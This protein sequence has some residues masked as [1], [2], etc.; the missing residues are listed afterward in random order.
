VIPAR[1]VW[2]EEFA[3]RYRRAGYWRGETLGA[4]LC[5]RAQRHQ[6]RVAVI[7]GEARWTYSELY[8]RARYVAEAAHGIGLR[9]GDRAIVQ[10]PNIPEFFSVTFGLFLAGVVPVFAL[11]A[12]RVAEIAHFAGNAEAEAYFI[13]STHDGFDYRDLAAQVRERV[14]GVKHVIVAA[15][16]AGPFLHL[17]EW[18]RTDP[19]VELPEIAAASVALMQLSGGSTGISKL[20]PR[21]HDDYLY[22]IRASVEICGLDEHSV[23]MAT[24]PVAHNFPM[25]SPGTFGAF[26]AGAH[27]VLTP[28]LRPDVA[29]PIIERERV[30]I[31]GVVPPIALVWIEAAANKRHDLSS[32]KVLQIGGAKLTPEVAKRVEPALGVKLQQVFGMAEGLVNYTRLGDPDETVVNTQGRPISPDDEILIVDDDGTPVTPGEPGHLLTRGPYTIR[33]YHNAPEANARAFTTDGYYRTG[34]IVRRTADGY[35]VVLGR[36]TDQINRGGEKISAEEVEDHLLAHPQVHDA[37]LV[38]VP[39]EYLGERACAFIIPRGD[40]GEPLAFKAALKSWIRGRGLA[41]Y[42]APDQIVIVDAFPSTGVGKISRKDLRA[43][44]RRQ[45]TLEQVGKG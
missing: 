9:P 42:K 1:Q 16:D 3:E 33:A 32:L 2:P 13:P 14:P 22:S 11:P 19:T 45:M 37:V 36:A 21:T 43:A 18:Q 5:E 34:D 25:S 29:F 39:D 41:A 20:I 26:Y 44:L 35:F 8:A 24:L 6:N 38:S 28:S 15:G 4:M 10:L 17:D 31:T 7:G 12:H 27:V 40:I 23:Y 30:T